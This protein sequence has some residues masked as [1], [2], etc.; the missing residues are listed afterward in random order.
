MEYIYI[1]SGVRGQDSGVY[2]SSGVR[3]QDSGVY[4]YLVE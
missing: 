1:S 3:G 2:I 4:I